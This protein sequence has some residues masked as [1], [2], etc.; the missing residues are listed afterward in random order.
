MLES[1]PFEVASTTVELMCR[2]VAVVASAPVTLRALLAEAPRSLSAL[3]VEHRDGWGMAWIDGDRWTLRK[4]T[5]CAAA[6]VDY[7]RSAA[8]ARS[9]LAIAHV[10]KKTVGGTSLANTHPFRRGRWV[11]AHNG[12]VENLAA[13]TARCSPRRLAEIDGDTDSERLFALLMTFIDEHEGDAESGLRAAVGELRAV[14]RLGAVNFFL[15]EGERLYALRLG[16]SLFLLDRTR[17][18]GRRTPSLAVASE[19]LTDEPWSDIPEG[20]LLVLSGRDAPQARVIPPVAAQPLALIHRS[21][22]APGQG[23]GG[24]AFWCARPGQVSG[25]A[26]T[27]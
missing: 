22:P 20:T 26:A 14:P 5:D 11:M 9:S 27:G 16:R 4:G 12:T 23:C 8:E 25:I 21:R 13:V 18:P 15:S 7:R 1:W 19:Q 2:M 3:S 6:C 10:R 17:G 24:V